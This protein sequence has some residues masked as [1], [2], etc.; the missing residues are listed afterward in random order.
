MTTSRSVRAAHPAGRR[1]R[2]HVADPAGGQ[3]RPPD[4]DCRAAR[5]AHRPRRSRR[6]IESDFPVVVDRT[7]RW[8]ATGYGAHAE[9]P[10]RPRRPPG[11]WPRDRPPA[12]SRSST[13]SRTPATSP[14]SASGAV[15]PAG[16]AGADHEDLYHRAAR[17]SHDSGRWHR[18]E[19]AST[20][21]SGVVTATQ[22][23]VVER[24]M[25]LNR[26]GQPFA[27]GHGSAGVTTPA[28]SWFLAEGATGSFFELFV[29]IENPTPPG[30]GGPRRL[31]AARRAVRLSKQYAVAAGEPV[32]HLGRRRAA[33]G[34]VGSAPAGIDGR[35]H[36]GDL[37]ERRAHHRRAVDVVAPAG[38][39]TRRTTR[40]H[41]GD[42]DA[43]GAWREASSA[44]PS[45]PRP[46]CSIANTAATAGVARVSLY[47]EDG[48]GRHARRAAA[49]R[50]PHQHRRQQPV[51]RG[52]R[53][54]L[55]YA[56]RER[57]RRARADRRRAGDVRE[58]RRRDVGGRDGR[59]RDAPDALTLGAARPSG[60]SGTRS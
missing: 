20:D 59:G 51:S 9:R 32:H 24:A 56:G 55:Q 46:T 4:R 30:R 21:V 8:D 27:A 34:R 42:G 36:A 15:P 17:A 45:R 39:G 33:A 54:A 11:T 13:C 52:G 47:F 31:P 23:I 49:G 28:T 22:P 12:T 48:A 53:E 5:V 43:V 3:A 10:S 29:L 1:R 35:R 38:S 58:P 6:S 19:L 40:R 16:A 44:V 2:T 37:D 50:E 25:Y 14:P 41:D 18:P 57:G 60:L 7:V 26:P